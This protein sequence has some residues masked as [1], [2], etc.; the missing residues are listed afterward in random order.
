[1]TA[2]ERSLKRTEADAR[3]ADNVRAV[4]KVVIHIGVS[5]SG[6]S[7]LQNALAARR[8]ELIADQWLFPGHDHNQTAEFISVLGEA[9]P[10][11]AQWKR[12]V[13]SKRWDPMMKQIKAAPGT[14]LLSSELLAGLTPEGIDLILTELDESDVKIVVTARDLGRTL[15]SMVQQH[16][17]SG[18]VST[19]EN[20]YQRLANGRGRND[21]DLWWWRAFELPALVERWQANPRVSSIAL[22]TAPAAGTSGSL[23]TRFA[24]AI[25][26][27]LDRTHAPV[28]PLD[29]AN[30]ALDKYQMRLIR[31]LNL[32]M[33]E[34]DL[35]LDSQVQLRERLIAKW[36]AAGN[37]P[38]RDKLTIHSDRWRQVVAGWAAEDIAGL[39][40]LDFELSGDLDDLRP[41]FEDELSGDQSDPSQCPDDELAN[42]M[43]AVQAVMAQQDELER[44]NNKAVI[45]I[46]RTARRR[47]TRS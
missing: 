35:A 34:T 14:V 20:Y 12:A 6:T 7:Y 27:P 30:V 16:F 17:K 4:R 31:Y 44:I 33:L 43:A 18:R 1:M 46:G 11:G 21:P 3:V 47:L 36:M 42:L 40:E 32:E 37:G 38:G 23:W 8:A 19:V 28:M 10:W 39:K 9:S 2:A 29:A 26:L 15:P 13:K 41:R 45:R 24:D 22:V 25:D 5:K